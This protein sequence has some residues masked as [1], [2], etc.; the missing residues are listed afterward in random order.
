MQRKSAIHII[1]IDFAVWLFTFTVQGTAFYRV[2]F[3]TDE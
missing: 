1:G 3:E 2:L